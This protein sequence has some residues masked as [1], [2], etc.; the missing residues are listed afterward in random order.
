MSSAAGR[1]GTRE[2]RPQRGS[3][4]QP[5][6]AVAGTKNFN[7]RVMPPGWQ[8]QRS[9]SHSVGSMRATRRRGLGLGGSPPSFRSAPA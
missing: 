1:D 7:K 9:K 6:T 2:A 8:G 3:G 5:A 4:P